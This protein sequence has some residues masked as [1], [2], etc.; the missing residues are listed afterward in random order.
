[1]ALFSVISRRQVA[2]P[3]IFRIE[4]SPIAAAPDRAQQAIPLLAVS[5]RPTARYRGNRS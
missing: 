4:G 3:S 2:V 5:V 1:L